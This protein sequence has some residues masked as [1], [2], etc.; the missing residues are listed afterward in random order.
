M[1]AILRYID[2]LCL[3]IEA[4]LIYCVRTG[5][6]IIFEKELAAIQN[7]LPGF[8]QV[9][10]LSQPGAE[11]KGWQGRLRREIVEREVDRPLGGA[12]F[13]LCGPPPFM[14]VARSILKEMG[15][16]PG[17]VLQESFG[18][19]VSAEKTPTA[20]SGSIRVELLRSAIRFHMSSSETL[21]ESA[22]KNGVLIPSGCRQGNCG[23]CA[24]KLLSGN[25]Q[26]DNEQ[27]LTDDMRREGFILPCV[28][29]PLGDIAVEA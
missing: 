4:T 14:D 23:T 26:M 12:T 11:W 29:R 7:R 20:D 21:L 19:A 27:A 15:V 9:V 17:K 8:H 28:S 25:V 1:L 18:S 13:F 2:D 22:E 10:V 24:T 6:D 16:D 5:R 3:K